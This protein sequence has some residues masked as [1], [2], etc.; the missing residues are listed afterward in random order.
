MVTLMLPPFEFLG[1]LR[2]TNGIPS[3]L[4]CTLLPSPFPSFALD[5]AKTVQRDFNLL[6]HRVACDHDFLNSLVER[7]VAQDDYLKHLWNIY[8]RVRNIGNTQNIFLGLNRSDYMLHQE[9]GCDSSITERLY[10]T[11]KASASSLLTTDLTGV[12]GLSLRQVEFNLM[13]S[14]FCGLAQRMV[15]QHRISLSLCGIKGDQLSRVSQQYVN[16]CTP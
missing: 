8:E 5:L 2:K 12:P 4:S 14:S 10:C 1:I 16:E 7:V 11:E 9:P 15:E 13:A 6:F 3:T